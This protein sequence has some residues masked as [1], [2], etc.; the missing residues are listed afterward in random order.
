MAQSIMI[1]GLLSIAS[2]IATEIVTA[3]NAKLNN[4]ILKGDG[5][6]I[7][8]FGVA[9]AIAALKVALTN[10][11]DFGNPAAFI[12]SFSAYGSAVFATS[13]IFFV[14]IYQKL[15][16]D[17]SSVIKQPATPATAVGSA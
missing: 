10:G 12:A 3:V 7:L 9:F 17:I 16:L 6:F 8:S 1:L 14:A 13:Q 5:A 2:S 15:G 4:T 11:I